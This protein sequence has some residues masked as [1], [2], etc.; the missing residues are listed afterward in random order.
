MIDIKI[1][2]NSVRVQHHGDPVEIAV[3]MSIATNMIYTAFEGV[4]TVAAKVFQHAITG[5]L[6]PDAPTWKTNPGQ[7]TLTT[8][9][10]K[11]DAPTGQS[12]GTAD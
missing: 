1:D 7:V 12:Q 4:S 8:P 3:E 5:C 6:T 10:K 11:S 2:G 9:I